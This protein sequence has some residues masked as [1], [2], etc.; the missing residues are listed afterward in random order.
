M[1]TL[2]ALPLTCMSPSLFAS[3]YHILGTLVV[4][5]TH[6]FPPLVCCY[7][8]AEESSGLARQPHQAATP[9]PR[10]PC[11][12][13]NPQGMFSHVEDTGFCLHVEDSSL[14]VPLLVGLGAARRRHGCCQPHSLLA[15]TLK[16]ASN[17]QVQPKYCPFP[18]IHELSPT[19][20]G[21]VAVRRLVLLDL[22]LV[23]IATTSPPCSI[24]WPQAIFPTLCARRSPATN[25]WG[26]GRD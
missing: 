23:S 7:Q 4:V 5:T 16:D 9:A 25:R 21:C 22:Y 6:L 24:C 12:G 14:D 8:P 19:S 17:P 26:L 1:T 15:N 3:N 13:P 20:L 11:R 18:S 2:L 10:H